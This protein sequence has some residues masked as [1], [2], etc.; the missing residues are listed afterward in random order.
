MKFFIS[1]DIHGNFDI[2]F[3][4]IISSGF[5]FNNP[6]HKLIICGDIFDRGNQPKQIIDFILAHK[7]KIILIKGNHDDAALRCI[8]TNK[9]TY[10][11]YWNGTPFVFTVRI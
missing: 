11:D 1:S 2:W 10:E 7:D 3:R 5:D 8:K 4:S 9:F 6:N